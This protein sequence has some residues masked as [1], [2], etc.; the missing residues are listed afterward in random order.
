MYTPPNTKTI[1]MYLILMVMIISGGLQVPASAGI[2]TESETPAMPAPIAKSGEPAASTVFYPETL[3]L[4]RTPL[5]DGV[6]TGEGSNLKP[7]IDLL[8]IAK[9]FESVATVTPA[10]S[11]ALRSEAG[12][13]AIQ[14]LHLRVAPSEKSAVIGYLRHDQQVTVTGKQGAWGSLQ[15]GDLAGYAHS[16]YLRNGCE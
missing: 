14:S 5:R 7:E 11:I 16:H 3:V 8:R 13:T 2:A 10:S 15:F 4:R 9:Q 1:S 6:S 12:V